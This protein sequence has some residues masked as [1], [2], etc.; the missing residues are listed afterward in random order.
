MGN[1]PRLL[2]FSIVK[3]AM[4]SARGGKAQRLMDVKD[5]VGRA[6]WTGSREGMS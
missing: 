5:V 4:T 6:G 1:D 3:M 2:R